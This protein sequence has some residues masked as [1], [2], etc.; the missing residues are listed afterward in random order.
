[1]AATAAAKAPTCGEAASALALSTLRAFCA[2]A[3]QSALHDPEACRKALTSNVTSLLLAVASQ[4]A[5]EPQLTSLSMIERRAMKISGYIAECSSLRHTDPPLPSLQMLK[6]MRRK[7]PTVE[8]IRRKELAKDLLVYVPE[9]LEL[10]YDEKI[11]LVV[12]ALELKR[13]EID[14]ATN[15]LQTEGRA[16]VIAGKL[17]GD[18][19]GLQNTK[20][21]AKWKEDASELAM[22]MALPP[23]LCYKVLRLMHGD[24]NAAGMFLFDHGRKFREDKTLEEIKFETEDSKKT[25]SLQDLLGLSVMRGGDSASLL[26]EMNAN[27]E[28]KKEEDDDEDDDEEKNKTDRNDFEECELH[29]STLVG[30][31]DL[32]NFGQVCSDS[33]YAD[34]SFCVPHHCT[35]VRGSLV[36]V[37]ENDIARPGI[38]MNLSKDSVLDVSVDV[39]IGKLVRVREG[40]TP[41]YVVFRVRVLARSK[42]ALFSFLN[43]LDNHSNERIHDNSS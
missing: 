43:S 4:A 16:F 13:D 7:E 28:T 24:K 9:T 40:V 20:F 38:F 23:S 34:R 41:Q 21:D 32:R 15:W 26:K 42:G 36:Y 19:D 17:S 3:L 31:N 35:F 1:M 30:D 18:D 25:T 27:L 39:K 12:K 2:R 14:L 37:M 10:K 6:S 8:E 29:Y 22:A 33:M 5:P 11:R